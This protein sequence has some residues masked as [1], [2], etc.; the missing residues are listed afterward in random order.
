MLL[1]RC[2]RIVC[3]GQKHILAAK[4]EFIT[5]KISSMKVVIQKE[6]GFCVQ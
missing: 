2:V 3:Y 4:I 5:K 1:F 6:I